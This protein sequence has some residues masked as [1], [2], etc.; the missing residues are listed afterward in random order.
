MVVSLAQMF[1]IHYTLVANFDF[2]LAANFDKDIIF[3]MN[4]TEWLM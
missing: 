4:T 1:L 2:F 3:H